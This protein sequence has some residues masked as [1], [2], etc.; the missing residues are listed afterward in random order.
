METLAVPTSG[1]LYLVKPVPA[2]SADWS[3]FCV[4]VRLALTLME[5]FEMVSVIVPFG[6]LEG[7]V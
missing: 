5:A 7:M 6:T 2:L 4:P 3:P 1:K